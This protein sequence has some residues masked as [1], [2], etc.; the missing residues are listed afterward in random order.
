MS[1]DGDY[2]LP[3]YVFRSQYKGNH[4]SIDAQYTLCGKAITETWSQ[5]L[6]E[7]YLCTKCRRS[8]QLIL[9]TM[10][11]RCTQGT[12]TTRSSPVLTTTARRGAVAL[13]AVLEELDMAHGVKR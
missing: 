5:V 4:L 13:G 6:R 2:D 10:V 11:A 1:G 12:A 7:K 8:E 9:R 3:G